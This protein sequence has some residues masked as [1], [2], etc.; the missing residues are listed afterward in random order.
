MKTALIYARASANLL[1]C[2]LTSVTA[3]FEAC[4]K[5]AE[6]NDIQIVGLHADIPLIGRKPKYVNWRYIVNT[7]KPKYDYILIYEYSRIGRN[8][9]KSLNDRKKLKERGVRIVS[10]CVEKGAEIDP[11]LDVLADLQKEYE[12]V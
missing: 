2:G 9:T 8:I 4:K 12:K 3:Q 6:K 10:I 11:I 7:K 1:D 5:Y